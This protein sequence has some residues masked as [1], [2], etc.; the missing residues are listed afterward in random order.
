MPPGAAGSA[1]ADVVALFSY[2]P[3]P[4]EGDAIVDG[5]LIGLGGLGQQAA[6]GP[7]HS[8]GR[9]QGRAPGRSSRSGGNE[10]FRQAG[11]SVDAGFHAGAGA[12]WSVPA[13]APPPVRERPVARVL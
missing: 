11:V 9:C 1:G 5:E 2:L 7:M 10:C 8:C 4:A 12:G 13:E 3:P 6:F